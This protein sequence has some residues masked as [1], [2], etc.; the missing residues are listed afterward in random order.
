MPAPSLR[1]DNVLTIL[2][3]SPRLEVRRADVLLRDG[4]VAAIG[5]PGE[6]AG[7]GADSVVD[8]S[9]LLLAAGL[10]NGHMH[11]WDHYLK[12]CIENVPTEESMSII[13][14]RKPVALTPD[15]MYLRTM[16]GAIEAL[17]SGTTTLV[18][19]MSL[20]QQLSREHVDAA[21]QAYEDSGIRALMGFSMIDKAVVD[22]Y[23]DAD[24]TFPPALLAELRALPRPDGQALLD[25]V[26]SLAKTRHP[27]TS[28]VGVI[29]APSAPHRCTDE[30]LMACRRLADELDLP[31]MTH[32]Q[33]T[34]LQLVT[35]EQFY[36]ESLVA[37]LDRLGF[38]KPRTTLIHATW[39]SPDDIRLIADSGASVQYNPWSNAIMGSGLAPVRECLEAG[40]NVGVGTDGTGLLFGNHMISSL[41][42]G[43]AVSKLRG[44]GM[45]QWLTADEMLRAATE[46]GA[47]ALGLPLGRI[48]VG[49]KADLI[50]LNLDTT[51]FTPLN[52][53]VRQLVYGEKGQSLAW[54]V[55]AGQPVFRDGRLT[56]VNEHRLLE[57]AREAHE[58]LIGSLRSSQADS[59]PFQDALRAIYT[60]SLGCSIDHSIF[61]AWVEGHGIPD[62]EGPR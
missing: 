27:A 17:R 26:R 11:S 20:G 52:D 7:T 28:R 31:A 50:A 42:F 43:A 18:D 54:V 37:H 33:E 32:C 9:R 48:E 51:T 1:F 25:L 46:G 57:R 40:I 47:H 12:G 58:E 21:L 39:L 44:P 53:A 10:I 22:S 15:Q 3:G 29:V 4:L 45:D 30:F 55:V 5:A 19:D 14:P 61:P 8:G 13:R 24:K 34:R 35:A 23:H 16:V 41:G 59:Q 36:G 62:T 56:Q 6:L 2:P 60:C 38:L 49:A